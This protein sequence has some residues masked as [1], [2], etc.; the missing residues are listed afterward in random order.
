MNLTNRMW[1]P[2]PFVRFVAAQKRR[3][4]LSVTSLIGPAYQRALIDRHWDLIE[5]DVSD[6]VWA[7]FGTA[8]HNLLEQYSSESELVE[9]RISFAVDGVT[10]TGQPD[11]LE[12]SNG[13]LSDWKV[14]SVWSVIYGGKEDWCAQLNLYAYGLRQQG[15]IINRLQ[16]VCFL[17]DWSRAKAMAGGDYPRSMVQTAAQPL[18]GDAQCEKY[19]RGRLEAHA[20]LVPCTPSERW[21]RPTVYACMKEGRKSAVRLFTEL[22]EAEDF[23]E[24]NKLA[25]TVRAGESVRCLSYCPVRQFCDYG[26]SLEKEG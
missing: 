15:R 9:E 1:L 24:T 19:I 21:D 17:R 5:V 14:T 12:I 7:L 13:I 10:I 4:G 23:A 3:T 26:Q 16:N 22:G 11:V 2:E 18:W 6:S 20:S 8:V 25:V